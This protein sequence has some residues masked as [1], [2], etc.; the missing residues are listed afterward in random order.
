MRASKIQCHYADLNNAAQQFTRQS[1]GTQQLL[2]A[3]QHCLQQLQGGAW[4]GK[5][6]NTFYAELEREVLP[7]VQRLISAL[8]EASSA[9]QR[10]GQRLEQAER[11]A[12]ALF[13][14]G[15]SNAD[16]RGGGDSV[17]LQTNEQ[18]DEEEAEP[19]EQERKDAIIADLE[20]YGIA[21]TGA[22][23]LAELETLQD[24]IHAVA[25]HLEEF[26][27]QQYP[28]PG[29]GEAYTPQV[30][31]RGLFG[32]L[33]FE[34]GSGSTSSQGWW[35]RYSASS[36]KI[37]LW[38]NAFK[39]VL[40]SFASLPQDQKQAASTTFLILHELGHVLEQSQIRL[41]NGNFRSLLEEFNRTNTGNLAG[42]TSGYTYRA[43]SSD[44]DYEYQADAVANWLNSS[45]NDSDAGRARQSQMNSI[46]RMLIYARYGRPGQP[47]PQ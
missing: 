47:I 31:F 36:D 28:P 16:G 9:T 11:E 34:R 29:L 24:T 42:G 10:I 33:T 3:V 35:G 43:R 13:M 21:V 14:G 26:A 32:A 18:E 41:P 45:F 17:V 8:R 20:Q 23:S 25:N 19:T 12:G 6:A 27:V 39:N 7:G 1:E 38:D 40:T 44:V 22:W 2:R 37:T 15:A 46:M 30:I 4:R 5:G